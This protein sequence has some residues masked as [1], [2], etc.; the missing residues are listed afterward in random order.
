MIKNVKLFWKKWSKDNVGALSSIVAWNILTSI[1][2]IVAGLIAISGFI[3]QG[4]PSMQRGVIHH[5]SE[6]LLGVIS[7]ADLTNIVRNSI[8]HAV[9]WAPVLCRVARG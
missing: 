5:L 2:A 3:L 8:K 9:C 1:V 6:A 4:H 7:P